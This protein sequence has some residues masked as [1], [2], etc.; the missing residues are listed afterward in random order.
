MGL[1]QWVRGI[2][3]S[4]EKA[5]SQVET[6]KNAI[7]ALHQE[8]DVYRLFKI[9]DDG[10]THLICSRVD[11]LFTQPVRLSSIQTGIYIPNF[12]HFKGLNDRLIAGPTGLVEP[13]LTRLPRVKNITF[14]FASEAF[15]KNSLPCQSCVVCGSATMRRIRTDG[16]IHLAQYPVRTKLDNLSFASGNCTELDYTP[17]TNL[18]LADHAAPCTHHAAHGN[19]SHPARS[20][21]HADLRPADA[22]A[23]STHQATHGNPS[24]AA[25]STHHATHGNPSHAAP[26][27][28][29][30]T[31]GNPSRAAPSTRHAYLRPAD[32]PAPFT[33]HAWAKW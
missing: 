12:A 4:K 9:H 10:Y 6:Q 20:T 16:R 27:T 18:R 2:K 29:H 14:P 23:P 32:A 33:H 11:L 17:H 8:R 25:P 15:L 22:A 13:V 28:H 21:P 30:A 24:H 3:F 1:S 31:H 26:S 7:R 19:P 5:Y